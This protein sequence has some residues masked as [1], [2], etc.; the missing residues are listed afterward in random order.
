MKKLNPTVLLIIAVVVLSFLYLRSCNPTPI[1]N[2]DIDTTPD[3]T[4][5]KGVVHDT[6]T[7]DSISYEIKWLKPEK[8]YI[9][10][11]DTLYGDS[12]NVFETV[13]NDSLIEGSILTICTGEVL[14]TDLKYTP[15]FPKYITSV[16]TL[17]IVQPKVVIKEKWALY[18]GAIMGGNA[19]SFSLEPSLLVKTNKN[20]QFSLGYG[21]INKTY[22]VGVYTKINNPFKK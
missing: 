8:E 5:I 13:Y 7:F 9:T 2:P 14:S 1:P 4:Y 15:K 20:L 22:N 17:R 3:S 12:V 10:V 18:A 19:T 6:V 11:H 21:L 16:D